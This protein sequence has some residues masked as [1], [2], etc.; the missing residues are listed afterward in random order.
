MAQTAHSF[1]T[2]ISKTDRLDYW[3]ALPDDYEEKSDQLFPLM[4]FLHGIGERSDAPA[5]IEAVKVHGPP[6]RIASGHPLP[7]IVVSPQCPAE[8]WWSSHVTALMRLLD[9]ITATYRVDTQRVYLTGL[10]MGGFGTWHLAYLYPE[11]FAAAAPV[12]GGLAWFVGLEKAAQRM[13]HLPIWAFHGAK[14]ATVPIGESQR[15]I[16]ALKA[17]GGNVKFTVYRNLGHDSWT[18]T[19]ANP[20]LYEWFLQHRLSSRK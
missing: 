10:S 15:V 11:R 19:Y 20:K 7:F 8:N 17:A 1:E 12:C 6:K 14:D 4:L 3:L 2:L 13:K 16:E 18:K 9:H 5:G